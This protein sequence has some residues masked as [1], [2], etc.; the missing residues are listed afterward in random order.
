MESIIPGLYYKKN[1]LTK[2]ELASIKKHLLE[3]SRWNHITTNSRRVIQ[4]GY[5]YSYDRSGVTKILNMPKYYQNLVSKETL[6]ERIEEIVK[7]IP[8]I[9]ESNFEQLIINEYLPG[10]GISSHIDHIKYFGPIIICIS[11][12]SGAEMVFEKDGDKKNFYIEEGSIYIMS[13]DARY[14]WKHMMTKKKKDNNKKRNIRYSLTFRT[15]YK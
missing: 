14:K 5:S 9:C 7:D 10:Q 11:V 3:S 2:R 6:M 8:S 12:G 1:F 13:G 4:Y 15:I